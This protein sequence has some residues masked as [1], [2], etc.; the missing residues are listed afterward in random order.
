[1]YKVAPGRDCMQPIA[2][3]LLLNPGNTMVLMADCNKQLGRFYLPFD[4]GVHHLAFPQPRVSITS[5]QLSLS[6][7]EPVLLKIDFYP[8]EFEEKGKT[9]SFQ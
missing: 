3:C 1:M 6:P 9:F 7:A 4:G 2:G 8:S 5:S